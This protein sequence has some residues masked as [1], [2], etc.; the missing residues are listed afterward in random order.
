MKSINSKK[1]ILI[2]GASGFV[3]YQV[4]LRLVRMK[5]MVK[6]V[7]REKINFPDEVQ[8]YIKEVIYT[9]DIFIETKKWWYKVLKDVNI[10]IHLAWYLKHNDFLTSKKNIQC[11]LGTIKIVQYAKENNLEKFIG[12]G[13]FYEYDSS[14]EYMST[15]TKLKPNTL[16]G[17]CKAST[18]LVTSEI[19]K[20]SNVQFLWIRLFNIF[21]EGEKSPRLY[22]YIKNQILKKKP[23]EI[24]NGEDVRDFMNVKDVSEEIVKLI[25]KKT[26]GAYNLCSGEGIRILDFAKKILLTHNSL[27]L[28][29]YN[30]IKN[31]TPFKTIG[32]RSYSEND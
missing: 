4:L 14:I 15:E 26:I 18:F 16:Y 13:T 11:M 32:I 6:L 24:I 10:C 27:N 31:N 12:I 8:K 1:L 22:P 7:L 17:S 19:L 5:I 28:L 3:G 23:V 29:K 2:T 21:G 25:F 30:K 20:S 9:K